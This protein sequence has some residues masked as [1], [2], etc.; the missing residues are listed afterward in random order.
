MAQEI[1]NLLISG[2]EEAWEE[3]TVIF[4]LS[5]CI[6][7]YTESDLV[8]K[9]VKFGTD[10]IDQLKKYPCIFA[11][12][13]YCE[14]NASVGCITDILVRQGKVK[15][16]FRKVKEIPSEYLRKRQFELDIHEW[17][18]N[19]THW[20][21]KKVNL[22]KELQALDIVL[23]PLTSTKPIDITKHIFDISFTFAGES[24]DVVKQIVEELG[25]LIDE[26]R[27]FYD[28]NYISQLAR[29]SLDTLLQDIYRNRSK[30]IVVF[31]CEKYQDKKWCGLEFRAIREL[32]MEKEEEKIMYIRL[33][34]GHVDGV[35]NTDGY[36]DGNKFSSRQLA[37]F[38]YERLGLLA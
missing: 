37:N 7:E 16:V 31:L 32:I 14:K 35:F 4:D 22:F 29:P 17:E 12:E 18:L 21:L 34:D 38:I 5:R 9:Y 1:Y 20:A 11:Y 33:D 36:I 27:I 8:E 30:L 15:I 25:Q 24:R 13:D 26:S 6:R 10:E 3:D 23:N 2:N 28:N 19:R